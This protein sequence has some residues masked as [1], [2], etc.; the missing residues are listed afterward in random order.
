MIASVVRLPIPLLLSL[1]CACSSGDL[2][3]ST[4]AASGSVVELSPHM[5][6]GADTVV[7]DEELIGSIRARPEVSAVVPR[8]DLAFPAWGS[9]SLGGKQQKVV[10]TCDGIDPIADSFRAGYFGGRKRPGES[11]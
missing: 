9:F 7:L 5:T 11:W 4:K 3:T 8:L 10:L 6:L 2:K 1:L